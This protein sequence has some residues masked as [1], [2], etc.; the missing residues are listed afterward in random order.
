MK[1]LSVIL[2]VMI[3]SASMLAAVSISADDL[4]LGDIPGDTAFEDVNLAIG[5]GT[6]SVV[7]GEEGNL[8]SVSEGCSISFPLAAGDKL[9][10]RVDATQGIP[11]LMIGTESAEPVPMALEA[12]EGSAAVLTY[13]AESDGTFS[14]TAPSG[15]L[16][17]SIAN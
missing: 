9:S 6:A 4:A 12:E 16:I 17:Y 2:G 3:L 1:K 10:V 11:S 14:L 8:L 15:A 13:A 7:G 5:T